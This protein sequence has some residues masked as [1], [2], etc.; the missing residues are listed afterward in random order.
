MWLGLVKT[1]LEHRVSKCFRGLVCLLC[2]WIHKK[3]MPQTEVTPSPWTPEWGMVE[4]NQTWPAAWSQV[5]PNPSKTTALY[6]NN[7]LCL[8]ACQW[9]LVLVSMQQKSINRHFG[10]QFDPASEVKH[11]LFHSTIPLLEIYIRETKQMFIIVVNW[12][13]SECPSTGE[14]INRLW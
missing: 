11:T 1:W 3:I 10:K 2:S 12:K 13:Q 6:L 14:W 4:Q 7:N 5:Q 8:Y 9:D